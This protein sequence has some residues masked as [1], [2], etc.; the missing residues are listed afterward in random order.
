MCMFSTFIIFRGF[1]KERNVQVANFLSFQKKKVQS[2]KF[3]KFFQKYAASLQLVFSTK[4]CNL[5]FKCC[6]EYFTK[7]HIVVPLDKPCIL[8]K[9]E[10]Y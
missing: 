6:T 10:T 7:L 8:Y 5:F 9:D 3:L 2:L 4:I 1:Q